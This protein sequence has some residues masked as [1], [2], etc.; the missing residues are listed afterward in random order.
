MPTRYY[1]F[2]GHKLPSIQLSEKKTGQET[3]ML[4]RP[5]EFHTQV[6]VLADLPSPSPS[7]KVSTGSVSSARSKTHARSRSDVSGMNK[8][9]VSS[10]RPVYDAAAAQQQLGDLT[11]GR[12][13]DNNCICPT[14][15]STCLCGAQRLAPEQHFVQ[16]LVAISSRLTPL[17]D[18]ETRTQS[19]LASLS[20]LN[21]NLPARVWLPL[22]A[23]DTPHYIVR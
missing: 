5:H 8:M 22:Y 21:L 2:T 23:A 10:L 1:L 4:P 12:A 6:S 19:L 7:P 20:M 11:T 15:S 18:K 16:A 9:A 17:P 14:N 13:F 3:L